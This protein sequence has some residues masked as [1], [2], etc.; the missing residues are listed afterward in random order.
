MGQ[1]AS[2]LIWYQNPHLG[3]LGGLAV[4][5]EVSIGLYAYLSAPVFSEDY[6]GSSEGLVFY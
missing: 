5:G 2:I 3:D 6:A 4:E 1:I